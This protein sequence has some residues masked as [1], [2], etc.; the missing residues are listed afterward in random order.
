[1]VD[2]DKEVEVE[3]EVEEELGGGRAREI[4]ARTGAR[5]FCSWGLRSWLQHSVLRT[6]TLVLTTTRSVRSTSYDR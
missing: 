4:D 3:V 5:G 2:K 1:M 6:T